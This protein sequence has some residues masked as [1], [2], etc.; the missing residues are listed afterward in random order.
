MRKYVAGLKAILLT[1]AATLLLSA[2]SGGGSSSGPSSPSTPSNT[3]SSKSFPLAIAIKNLVTSGF[4]ANLS[5]SGT[6]EK[7]TASGTATISWVPSSA[8]TFENQAVLDAPLL[9]SVTLSANGHSASVSSISHQYFKASD[10]SPLGQIDASNGQYY[11]VTSFS[12]WP[13]SVKVG[14]SGN[15]GKLT[16]YSDS[17]KALISGYQ[18]WS[19]SI[20]ADTADTAIIALTTVE[21]DASNVYVSTETDRYRMT[22]AGAI[23]FLSVHSVDAPTSPGYGDLTL[24]ATTVHSPGQATPP[25]PWSAPKSVGSTFT[26]LTSVSG[27][28]SGL[29]SDGLILQLNGGQ[30]LTITANS[31]SFGFSNLLTNETHYLVSVQ[32]QPAGL[33]C[34]V[35]NGTGMMTNSSDVT[36]VSVTCVSN[37]QTIGG[38]IHGLTSNGLV[39]KNGND[40]ISVSANANSFVFPTQQHSAATYLVT[41]QTQP[42]GLL[43]S[44]AKQ[45]GIVGTSA[46]T[47]VVIT[48]D[49]L[50]AHCPAGSNV[51][52]FN[53]D[54]G[55][56]VFHG[57]TTY[58]QGT[59][60]V[61]GSQDY[62][63]IN[64]SSQAYADWWY[65]TFSTRA[66]GQ[67]LSIG[68]FAQAE[69]ASFASSGRPGIDITGDGSGCNTITGDFQIQAITWSG[70]TLKSFTASFEQH[71][72][73]SL[74]ALRGCVHFEQ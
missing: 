26:G 3:A 34:N 11:L 19:Y 8:A 18:Q 29:T 53:G 50:I 28:I 27:N 61:S 9:G 22:S 35:A 39:L 45:S 6:I 37:L 72:E 33:N 16:L 52:Y 5:I 25:A 55:D 38:S 17:S 59:W 1:C 7:F 15:L 58:T 2:C 24:S 66:M 73:G 13:A 74:I 12:G 4:D 23:T 54:S 20:E 44:V 47:D 57:S 70:S 49:P 51:I 36:N 65:L 42:S 64:Y 21:T 32:T 71:C 60:S 41:V 56:Y 48:C 14:D 30:L 62:L 46:V 67:S 43:C 40:T 68:T 69:R 10:Y 31:T 63:T